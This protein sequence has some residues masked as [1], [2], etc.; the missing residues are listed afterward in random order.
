MPAPN[1]H[2]EGGDNEPASVDTLP[3]DIGWAEMMSLM[4]ATGTPD[5]P[6]IETTN[7]PFDWRAEKEPHKWAAHRVRAAGRFVGVL[8]GG[9]CLK[10][11]DMMDYKMAALAAGVAIVS[12]KSVGTRED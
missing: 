7:T 6:A 10:S 4:E 11:I 5:M 3:D 12:F 2:H 8:A 9:V 1:P